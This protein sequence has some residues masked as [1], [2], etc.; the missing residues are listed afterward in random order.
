MQLQP[1]QEVVELRHQGPVCE[2]FS[3][4]VGQPGCWDHYCGLQRV[5]V[6]PRDL[7]QERII[8]CREKEWRAG[9]KRWGSTWLLDP[10][11]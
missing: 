4:G 2:D 5:S 8:F 9:Y 3:E 6:T 7:G 1:V 10:R 11:E